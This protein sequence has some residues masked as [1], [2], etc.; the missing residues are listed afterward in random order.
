MVNTA[1]SQNKNNNKNDNDNN[2]DD[3]DDDDEN[4]N[5][6][7]NKTIIL[8]AITL[9]MNYYVTMTNIDLN[10]AKHIA[11]MHGS[12]LVFVVNTKYFCFDNAER[13]GGAETSRM[14]FNM[15]CVHVLLNVCSGILVPCY[16]LSVFLYILD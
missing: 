3:D 4:K 9:Q 14:F 7:N 6:V 2:N 15:V 13:G 1:T 12:R 10:R 8:K 16:S 5:D 11:D